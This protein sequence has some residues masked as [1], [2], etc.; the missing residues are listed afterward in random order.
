MAVVHEL[1][2]GAARSRPAVFGPGRLRVP[3]SLRPELQKAPGRAGLPGSAAAPEDA[4]Q[5]GTSE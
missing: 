5:G 2:A 3:G 4:D 1:R